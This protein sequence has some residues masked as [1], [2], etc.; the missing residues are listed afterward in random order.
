MLNTIL[1]SQENRIRVFGVNAG[2]LSAV[3]DIS[4]HAAMHYA[5]SLDTGN[6]RDTDDIGTISALWA[7]QGQ[8][9]DASAT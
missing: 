6:I 8:G 2:R 4:G 3:D 9:N 5:A 1:S 7:R